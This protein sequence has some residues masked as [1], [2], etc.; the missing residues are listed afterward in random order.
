MVDELAFLEG[1]MTHDSIS[2]P[3][4]VSPTVESSRVESSSSVT[5]YNNGYIKTNLY[6]VHIHIEMFMS[7]DSKKF[8]PA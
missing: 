1:D 8:M 4:R 3:I 5:W 7:A 6:P 2:I